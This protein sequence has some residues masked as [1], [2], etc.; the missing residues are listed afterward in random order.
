MRR[1]AAILSASLFVLVAITGCRFFGKKKTDTDSA[2]AGIDPYMSA[3]SDASYGSSDPYPV[4]GSPA[5]VE[6]TYEPPTRL[7]SVDTGFAGAAESRQH[8]VVKNDTLYAL[9]R[10]Y[11]GDQRRW[12]EI[13]EAN[14]SSI[15]DP[16]KIR[17]GQR[18][19]IP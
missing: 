18:L 11:Y 16:N 19:V 3:T 8:T 6:R 7:T 12:K 4:Y 5:P 15:S 14:R 1:N 13:Y 17:V 10:M 2:T 9:A